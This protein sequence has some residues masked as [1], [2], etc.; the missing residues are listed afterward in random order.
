MMA[1]PWPPA[2]ATV[3]VHAPAGQDRGQ[4]RPQRVLAQP[5]QQRLDR[6]AARR[7]SPGRVDVDLLAESGQ[8]APPSP[9]CTGIR[10]PWFLPWFEVLGPLRRPST[11][12]L[13]TPTARNPGLSGALGTR[14]RRQAPRP[15]RSRPRRRRARRP[16]ACR[17][18]SSSGSPACGGTD[19]PDPASAATAGVP[20][21]VGAGLPGRRRRAAPGSTGPFSPRSARVE[22]NHGQHA[23]AAVDPDT[24]EAT[25][26]IFGPR[27]RRHRPTPPPSPSAPGPAGGDSPA[28]G[29][30]PSG[31]CSS[32]PAP[33][34]AHA[35]DADGDGA[36]NPHDIDDAV[37]TTAAYICSAAGDHVDGPDEIARIYNP[38]DADNYAAQL[39][40]RTATASTDAGQATGDVAA[41]LCPVAGPVTFT[42]TWGAPRSGGRAHQGVDMFAA[43]G[44]PVVAV[45]AGRVEHY[46][47]SLGGLSYRLYA[48]DGT[49]YYGTHLSAYANEGAGHVDAGTVIGYVGRTGNAATTPPHLHWEIHPDGRGTPA[50]NPTPTADALCAANKT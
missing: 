26:W 47:N 41:G 33:S 15:T 42:D 31:P 50:I 49:F 20:A 30:T 17:S 28:R 2:G 44:T 16:V 1:M 7:T 10:A 35:V 48:D 12:E 6:R 11:A 8:V 38:G 32:S 21:R 39:D 3:G 46:N 25:P 43:E 9:A 24:G 34:T 18:C 40:R 22:T 23:G 19:R 4:A 27:A 45:A 37:A 36:T 5:V 29:N 13:L 14:G